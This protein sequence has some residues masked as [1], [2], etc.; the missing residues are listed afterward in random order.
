MWEGLCAC[1]EEADGKGRLELFKACVNNGPWGKLMA[2]K[3]LLTA[4]LTICC[5][6]LFEFLDFSSEVET[7]YLLPAI[8]WLIIQRP[9]CCF[10]PFSSTLSAA[11][12]ACYF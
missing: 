3:L 10:S 1:A 7:C 4:H 11:S 5:V 6:H 9:T 2:L 12:P 8:L